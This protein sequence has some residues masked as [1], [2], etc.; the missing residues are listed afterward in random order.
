M[1]RS[2]VY[3]SFLLPDFDEALVF[4]TQVLRW[5]VR[6]DIRL[7]DSKRWLVVSLATP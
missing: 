4:S 7:S 2:L 6:E 5:R 1:A 3:T